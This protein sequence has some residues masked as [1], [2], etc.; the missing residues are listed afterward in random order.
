ML[1]PCEHQEQLLPSTLSWKPQMPVLVM[2][3]C[4]RV[5]ALIDYLQQE[6][7]SLLRQHGWG[8]RAQSSGHGGELLPACWVLHGWLGLPHVCC[9]PSKDAWRSPCLVDMNE[10]PACCLA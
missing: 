6:L 8:V 4:C 9:L 1:A 5:P 10:G 3:G 2:T 7:Q